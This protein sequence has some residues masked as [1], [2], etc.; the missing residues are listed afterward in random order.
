[1]KSVLR[2]LSLTRGDP[3]A[4]AAVCWLHADQIHIDLGS[5]QG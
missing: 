5:Q 4:I 3:L 1:M 2:H